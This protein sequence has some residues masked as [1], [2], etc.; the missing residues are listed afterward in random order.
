MFS[1]RP[2]WIAALFHAALVC[3]FILGLFYYWFAI[4]DRYAI[5][6]YGHLGATP[7]DE[8]TGS[9]YWMAGLV[10]CGAVMIGYAAANW[11]WACIRSGYRPPAWRQ[12]WLICV[13]PLTAGIIFITTH[14]N[15]PTLP[16]SNAAACVVATLAGLI[17]ALAAGNLAAQQPVELLWLAFDGAGL[18]PPLLLLRALE[19][20]QRGLINPGAAYLFAL[21]SVGATII[22]SGVM[23]GLRRW[24]GK[25]WPSAKALLA[26]GFS[27]SYLLLPLV[28]HLFS[29]PREYRYISA[30][31]NFFAFNL[32]LQ[33]AV[34]LIAG[35][36]AMSITQLRRYVTPN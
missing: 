11:G 4:A 32:L 17:L 24:Q 19:L 29:T 34:F 15:R 2:A 9:R 12:V 20:P 18:V 3:L 5:F 27:L 22:W 7:F 8:V 31:S 35:L 23:T 26:A 30:A 25:P 33:L 6:L 10:A 14:F 16:L 13:L 28:H 36:L 21:G 1:Q